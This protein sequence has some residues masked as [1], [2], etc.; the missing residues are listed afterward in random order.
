MMFNLRI[1]SIFHMNITHE[2]MEFTF[3]KLTEL[4]FLLI[5][6]CLICITNGLGSVIHKKKA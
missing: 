3:I 5:K 6:K 2:L 1:N 4:L